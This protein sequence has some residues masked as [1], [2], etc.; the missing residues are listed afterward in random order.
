MHTDSSSMGAAAAA[1]GGKLTLQR[2]NF[3]SRCLAAGKVKPL[4]ISVAMMRFGVWEK[5]NK[6]LLIQ[7]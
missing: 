4:V 7:N 5:R 6:D 3:P 1:T 2:Q